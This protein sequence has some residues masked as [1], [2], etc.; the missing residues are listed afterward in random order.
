MEDDAVPPQRKVGGVRAET[1]TRFRLIENQVVVAI[2]LA[3]EGPFTALLDV[4]V[5]PSVIDLALA[6]DL[7]LS[8]DETAPG[9]AAGHGTER[10]AFYPAELPA[11]QIGDHFVGDIEA[12]A[13]DLA[14]IGAKLGRPLHAIL[15][16]S[17][18][19]GRVVRFD[20]G[21]QRLTLNPHGVEDAF[22]LPI[23]G[24][25]DL[26]PVVPVTV[27][28]RELPVVLDTG[29]SLTLGI[30][31]DAV[32]D[33]GL[34]TERNAATPRTVTGARGQVEAYEGVVASLALGDVRLER[35]PTV[36]LPR[37]VNDPTQALGNLGNGFLQ[38][39][40]L[41]LDYPRR[42]LSIRAVRTV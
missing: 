8:I 17:F 2:R 1:H 9:E 37:P 27:N 23:E 20:Y 6:R 32:E 10:A 30:Y 41:T 3:G 12:V 38:H 26:T 7:G 18:F 19:A 5:E 31:L 29:S 42:R 4:A 36:F 35:V 15:G 34:A 25:T 21:Q 14:L 28:G 24:A 22:T 33:L 11:V 16:Q 13:A 39:A 40:I